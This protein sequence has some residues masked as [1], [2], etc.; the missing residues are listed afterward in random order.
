METGQGGPA[1]NS[2]GS[3][4][5]SLCNVNICNF[6]G[7]AEKKRRRVHGSYYNLKSE[8][9]CASVLASLV[10][11]ES[12]QGCLAPHCKGSDI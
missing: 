2:E 4:T 11:M 9:P 5:Y 3:D 12:G 1:P 8:D 10:A 7:S 6:S